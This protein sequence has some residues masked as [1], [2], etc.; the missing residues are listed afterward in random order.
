[1]ARGGGGGGVAWRGGI[2]LAKEMSGGILVLFPLFS[3]PLSP[4]YYI[5]TIY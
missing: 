2:V 1:M 5:S 3:L 4:Q